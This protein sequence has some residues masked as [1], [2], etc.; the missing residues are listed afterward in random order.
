MIKD[1]KMTTETNW[2]DNY[3]G[4]TVDNLSAEDKERIQAIEDKLHELFAEA[5]ALFPFYS[6]QL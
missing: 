4:A 3:S 2:Y 6:P 5:E 1:F